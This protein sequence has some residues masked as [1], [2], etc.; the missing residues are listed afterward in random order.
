MQIAIVGGG[1]GGL[2][3]AIALQQRGF[4]VRV[5]EAAAAWQPVGK[6][7]W[8]PTNAFQ[9]LDRLGLSAPLTRR[10]C[11]LAKIE[12]LDRRDGLLQQVD[13]RL[14]AERLRYATLSIRRADLHQVLCD[15]LLPET[16]QLNRRCTGFIQDE[17]RVTIHFADGSET[18]ADVLIGLMACIRSFAKRSFPALL[19]GIAG[20]RVCAASPRLHCRHLWLI[21]V[22]N[23]GMAS[24][25]LVFQRLMSAMCTGLHPSL[26][27]REEMNP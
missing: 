5:Y 8:L 9:A 10:S 4:S 22:K 20:R 15:H 19:C 21:P 6:G 7:I 13:L 17:Q 14:I 18:V 23:G 16:C 27:Q 2:T 24:T 3:A 12:I 26:H 11:A 1:I 25:D